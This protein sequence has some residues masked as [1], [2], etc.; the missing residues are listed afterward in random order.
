MRRSSPYVPPQHHEL[1]SQLTADLEPVKRP[2]PPGARWVAWLALAAVVVA[3]AG[4]IG[5]RTD[6]RAVLG[7]R[8]FLLEVAAL[9]VGGASAAMAAFWAAVPGRGGSRVACLVAIAF[10]TA[11]AALLPWNSPGPS[12][13][14]PLFVAHGI[15]CTICV[16][17]FGGLPWLALFVAL[18]RGAPLAGRAAGAYAGVAAFLIG[19]AAVRIAC[20]IDDPI[21]VFTAHFLP[22]ALWSYVSAAAG[23]AWLTRWRRPLLSAV[24]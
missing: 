7:R 9:F 14:I 11:A 17:L 18:R 20:P 6:V 8:I 24:R 19:A 16:A 1:V 21:H 2:S 23:S 15:R 13:S 5:L 22:V 12:V 3:C 10:G 4:A